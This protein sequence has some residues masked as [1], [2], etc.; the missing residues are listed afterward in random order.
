MAA[1][2]GRASVD[3]FVPAERNHLVTVSADDRRLPFRHPLTGSAVVEP[4]TASA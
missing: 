3:D 4:T 1:A 2:V